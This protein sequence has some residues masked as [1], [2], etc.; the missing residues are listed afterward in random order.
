[1]IRIESLLSA[2]LFL[3]PQVVGDRIYFISNLNGRNSLYVMDHGGSVPQPLLPPHIALQNPHLIDGRSFVIFPQLGKILIMLDQDG[4]ESYQP[5]VIPID[6]GYPEP[7]FGDAFAQHSVFAYEPDLDKNDIFFIAQSLTESLIKSYRADLGAGELIKISEGRFG[8]MPA[9]VNE[10]H[11]KYVLMEQFGPGDVVMYRYDEDGDAPRHFYGVRLP[12]RQ[13]DQQIAPTAINS[14]HFSEDEQGIFFNS[15]LFDDSYSLGFMTFDHPDAP[16][17]VP[18]HGTRHEGQGELE[19]LEK[20]AG[21]RYLLHYN[22]DG[23]SWVYEAELDEAARAVTVQHTLVGQGELSGGVLESITYD[24]AGDRFA[25]SFS[26]AT[27]PTQIYTIEGDNRDRLIRHTSE[28]IL[29]IPQAWLSNGEDYPFESHDGLR[30]SARLYLP[31]P[32]LGFAGPRPL[33]YYIHGGPQ[34]Q[35]RPDFAWFSMPFIQYLTM[36]GFAVFVPNV[37][38]STGYGFRYMQHVVR[39]W[40]GQDRLDHVHAMTQVLPND[41]RIDVSR[42]GVVGRSYGG[43]MTLTLAA[44]HPELWSAAVDMFGPYD[45]LTF[46]DR[47]PET[48]KPFMKMLV[49]DPETEQDFLTER[50]PRTYIHDV[51]CPMLVIQGKND[52][53]V[54]EQESRELVEEL[55][56]QG[57]EVEYLMFPD[58]GH[59]VLKYDNRVTVYN[60]MTEFF[61]TQ[62]R[63]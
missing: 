59:D 41:P 56:G 29:G 13:P 5:M 21:N 18:I 17:P 11:N 1:M 25:L 47:V 30:I 58:E 12:D 62:L 34:S 45:L 35:E 23:C 27:S 51:T 15:I 8:M 37:R 22:I 42:A 4:D 38:G 10:A 19:R 3:V 2:R 6:G 9:A 44:R 53:R 55:R 36:N 52:P 49:G 24:E 60:R 28:R 43:F 54:I 14:L 46:A 48:W 40:G 50:S 7:I 31:A 61:K 33:V 39:D 63:P 20:L 26:T 57:K 32:E 16:Q